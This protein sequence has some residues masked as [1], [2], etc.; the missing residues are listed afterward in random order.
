MLDRKIGE[1]RQVGNAMLK[2]NEYLSIREYMMKMINN[3]I[4]KL[5]AM[6]P[7]L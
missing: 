7:R 4:I 5:D 6:S 1:S 3:S 2:C